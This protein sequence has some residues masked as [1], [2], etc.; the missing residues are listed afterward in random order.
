MTFYLFGK[1]NFMKIYDCFTFF[2][3]LDLL[4]IRLNELNDIVDYFVLIE[5]KKTFQNKDKPCY[6]LDNIER[7]NQFN[8]KII[9]LEMPIKDFCDYSWTNEQNS[10]NYLINGL[11]QASNEDLILVSA[12]DEVPNK[13]TIKKIKNDN[14]F[15][16]C[17]VM[18]LY[19]F[20]LN[21]KYAQ[22]GSTKWN[23]TY[24]TKFDLLNK[25]NIYSFISERKNVKKIEGGW[26]F[27]F[28]GDA[29]NALSKVHSYSHF[30][31]NKF[32]EDFYKDRINNLEDVF[33]RQELKFDS[34]ANM[35]T[36]PYHVQK[37]I[38]HYKKYIRL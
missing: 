4:E 24:V 30:E 35:D 14:F 10:W 23:G 13:E 36:L 17:V 7:F 3:E 21:T 16:M 12:L 28:L 38:E 6:Y 15:P 37:N 34:F 26:H 11:N 9:R 8:H 22:H 25:N 20:Y 31:F 1:I 2:N 18:D 27:S 19:Y 5:S 32:T 29:K 33:L